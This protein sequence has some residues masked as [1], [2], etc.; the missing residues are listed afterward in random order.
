MNLPKKVTDALLNYQLEAIIHGVQNNGRVYIA[1]EMGLGKTLEALSISYIFKDDWPLLIVCPSS[2]KD[3]W[4]DQ[5]LYWFYP[6]IEKTDIDILN[7]ESDYSKQ[8][9]I[10][11]YDMVCRIPSTIQ[12]RSLII[13]ESHYVKNASTKRFNTIFSRIHSAHRVILL[14]GTPISC[15]NLVDLITQYQLFPLMESIHKEGK[16]INMIQRF[17]KDNIQIGKKHR[18]YKFV[19]LNVDQLDLAMKMRKVSFKKWEMECAKIKCSA[20]LSTYHEWFTNITFKIVLFYSNKL[21]G[22]SF[23]QTFGETVVVIDGSVPPN[24]RKNNLDYFLSSTITKYLLLQIR[25]GGTGLDLHQLNNAGFIQLDWNPTT[26][27]QCEDRIYRMNQTKDCHIYYFICDSPS[28]IDSL[29]MIPKLKQKTDF[30]VNSNYLNE[31]HKMF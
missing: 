12:F 31:E 22:R 19:P 25:V 29:S 26:L 1:D 14:S 24:K 30:I 16:P 17:K 6:S 21:V 28:H 20:I 5:F 2:L 10:A 3:Q 9:L 4:K 8:I 15:A 13:D 18:H 27:L 7:K 23:L 11:S